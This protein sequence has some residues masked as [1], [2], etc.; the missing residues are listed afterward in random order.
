VKFHPCLHY[1]DVLI[2]IH[3]PR[4]SS[5][6]GFIPIPNVSLSVVCPPSCV[7]RNEL[8][9]SLNE[10]SCLVALSMHSCK[11]RK[12]NHCAKNM[13]IWLI[14]FNYMITI[15]HKWSLSLNELSCLVALSMHSCKSRKRNHCAKNMDIWLILFNYMIATWHKWWI[16]FDHSNCRIV[17]HKWQVWFNYTNS[18]IL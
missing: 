1:G 8:S 3:M 13:D 18:R 2:F 10:L 5:I 4:F 16:L 11:S 9:L 14:L 12:R 15:W 7:H 17:W 6:L